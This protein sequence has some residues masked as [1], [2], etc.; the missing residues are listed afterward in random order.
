MQ[1][2]GFPPIARPDAR[3]LILGSLPG[4]ES[5]RRQ[6]YY[7][8]PRNHFWRI[9]GEIFD[10]RPEL[11]YAARSLRLREHRIALWDV[12]AAAV[13]IGSLDA[14]IE[15][16]TIEVNDF[17]AFFVEHPRIERVYCNGSTAADLYQRRVLPSLPPPWSGLEPVRLPSTSPAHAAMRFEDKLARWREALGDERRD[18]D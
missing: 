17:A 10:A 12:C 14:S 8:Q 15:S 9:M 11:D 16:A 2:R 13:R 18:E 7:A 4:A 5:L 3:V 6:Q 1:S